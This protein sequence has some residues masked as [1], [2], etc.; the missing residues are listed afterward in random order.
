MFSCAHCGDSPCTCPD[1]APWRA[2]AD[3]EEA[4]KMQRMREAG[5]QAWAASVAISV[6][7]D[8]RAEGEMWAIGRA[9][10]RAAD[11]ELARQ[12]TAERSRS[13]LPVDHET[14]SLLPRVV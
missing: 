4:E 2:E 6:P 14:R 8:T 13:T 1:Y 5:P 3:R 12:L 10:A 7:D 11:D 9:W